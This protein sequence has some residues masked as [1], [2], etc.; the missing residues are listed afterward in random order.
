MIFVDIITTTKGTYNRFL[1]REG[2]KYFLL[3]YLP[4][5]KLSGCRYRVKP[6]ESRIIREMKKVSKNIEE[7]D[8]NKSYINVFKTI[9][10]RGLF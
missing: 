6:D 5:E 2:D 4:Y 8:C 10:N 9:E 3:A 1:K 7:Y